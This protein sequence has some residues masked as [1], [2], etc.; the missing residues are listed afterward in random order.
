M[1]RQSLK[2]ARWKE[3][4]ELSGVASFSPGLRFHPARPREAAGDPF[5]RGRESSKRICSAFE[6]YRRTVT[7]SACSRLCTGPKIR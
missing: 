7:W 1:Q 2:Q 3:E 4:A 5:F 6:L